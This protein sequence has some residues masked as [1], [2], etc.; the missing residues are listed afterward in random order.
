MGFGITASEIAWP[1]AATA[2]DEKGKQAQTLRSQRE[3]IGTTCEALSDLERLRLSR[4]CVGDVPMS[5]E[6]LNLP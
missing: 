1:R 5:E 6:L 3:K 4:S 2:A